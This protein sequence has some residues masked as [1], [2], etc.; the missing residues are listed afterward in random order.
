[1]YT[2]RLYKV[3]QKTGLFSISDNFASTD[4]RKACIV[5]KFNNFV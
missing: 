4:D 1:M 3:G 2:V 5:L